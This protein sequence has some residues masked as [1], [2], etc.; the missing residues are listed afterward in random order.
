MTNKDGIYEVRSILKGYSDDFEPS[1]RSI[2]KFIKSTRAKF[3]ERANNKGNLYG[4]SFY[5]SITCF[6]LE[7]SSLAECCS[8]CDLN[9]GTIYKSK[10]KLPKSINTNTGTPAI[11][12]YTIESGTL[13]NL[14]TLEKIISN[15][16]KKYK[17]PVPDAFIQNEYLFLDEEFYGVK[18]S[19]IFESPEE[20]E[21]LNTCFEYDNC[22][23]ITG[24]K[25]PVPMLE[26]DL[27]MSQALWEDI[28]KTVCVNIASFYGIAVPDTENNANND[29][30]GQKIKNAAQG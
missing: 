28:R 17:F 16:T 10:F 2:Y 18:V 24:T 30:I 7:P 21:N 13:I 23:H 3:A 20:V 1:D 4:S 8:E 12:I 19:G 29:S 9:L 25:C 11:K 27:N 14:E 26:R 6:P 22:G 5:Q 15:R